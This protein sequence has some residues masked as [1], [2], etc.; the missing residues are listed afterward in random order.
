MG[1]FEM[2]H[3]ESIQHGGMQVVNM[4]RIL[5]HIPTNFVGGPVNLPPFEAPTRHRH[6]E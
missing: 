6:A 5:G 2:I 3:A 1:Q 4:H